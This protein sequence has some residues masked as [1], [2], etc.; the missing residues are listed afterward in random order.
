MKKLFLFTTLIFGTLDQVKADKQVILFGDSVGSIYNPA[1]IQVDV[2]DTV[3][4]IGNFSDFPLQSLSVPEGANAFFRNSGSEPYQYIIT[5]EGTYSYHNPQ[6][7]TMV[8]TIQAASASAVFTPVKTRMSLYPSRTNNYVNVE[9]NSLPN[10]GQQMFLEVYTFT[11]KKLYSQIVSENK[12]QLSLANFQN[13]IYIVS[14]RENNN[15][16]SSARV[17][18]TE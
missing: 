17:V 5:T 2:G 12:I 16:I 4:F 8:G 15:L 14:V 10:A 11:G 7:A 1:Y 18:K 6:I 9:L 13:G 3:E